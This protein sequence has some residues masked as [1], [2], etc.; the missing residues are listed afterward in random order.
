MFNIR[1]DL[2]VEAREIYKK[3]NK[4]EVPGVKVDVEEEM[5]GIRITT[6]EVENEVGAKIIGKPI[7]IYITMEIPG[8][9]H[10]DADFHDEL[11]KS[12][13]KQLTKLV[14]LEKNQTALVV[15][16]GNWNVTPDS[17]GPKVVSKL[18]ITRHLKQYMP[19]Q[20]EEGIYSVCALSPGV[21]GITGIE[22]AEIIQ[23]VIE[24]I[25]PDVLIA[26]DA[27]SS[28]KMER[29]VSTIQL[30]NTGI[31]PGSG[32]GNKRMELTYK[33]L[34]IP[35]IAIGVPTVVDAATMSNDT[36]DLMID[37]LIEQS[38]DN[39]DFYNM[40]KRVDKEEKYGM[41]KEILNP[42][43][44]DLMVTPKEIDSLIEDM[45]KII[46]NGINI[47]LHPAIELKDVNRYVH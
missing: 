29:V 13:A 38:K 2:A 14:H 24:K 10:Y 12:L 26:I 28:R 44:G 6:V 20:I 39:K 36:I 9:R 41:I 1:T 35:V 46:A 17:L 47:C 42:Y 45:S 25:K 22:T 5:E 7:G 33:S 11:S 21:L 15:G 31:S 4:R 18:M 16:L 19:D 30:G 23:G 32:V 3:S 34:G 27:L 37:T 43:I 40:L 8:I